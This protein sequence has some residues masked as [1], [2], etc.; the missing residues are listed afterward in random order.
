LLF[1]PLGE[2]KLA[3][4]WKLQEIARE[5]DRAGYGLAEF[6]DYLANQVTRQPREDQAATVPE[7]AAHV[8][9]IMSVHQAKG[10]E[11]P[12]VIVPD[13][14]GGVREGNSAAAWW[15]RRLG[16]LVAIPGDCDDAEA[17]YPAW[18]CKLAKRVEKLADADEALRVL[19]VACTRAAELLILSSGV[20]AEPTIK[21]TGP[22]M[23][24][25]AR[26]F[27]LTTGTSNDGGEQ[28]VVNAVL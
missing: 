11:F 15:H 7:E 5:F 4:L 2:R 27:D 14:G 25:V 21:P 12:V 8:V 24:A 9:R 16:A 22:W 18:P 10:L 1:E 28:V 19:Y 3:N 17:G 23:E 20:V 26:A 6:I 13:L